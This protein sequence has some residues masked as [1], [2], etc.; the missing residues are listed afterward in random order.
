MIDKDLWTP[1]EVNRFRDF[2]YKCV[3][4]QSKDAVTLHELVPKSL[5]KDWRKIENRVP[6]CAECH[7]WA[8]EFGTTYSRITLMLEMELHRVR[9]T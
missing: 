6:I 7:E 3:H 5:T 9:R 8:H 2:G 1:E 4:C